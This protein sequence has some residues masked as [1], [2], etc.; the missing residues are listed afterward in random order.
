ML[1]WLSV[2][3]FGAGVPILTLQLARGGGCLRIDVEGIAL[4]TGRKEETKYQWNDIEEF[5]ITKISGNKFVSWNF[6]PHYDKSNYSAKLFGRYDW[7][8]RTLR[9]ATRS[10]YRILALKRDPGLCR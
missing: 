8:Y 1:G 5:G 4:G 3:F 7:R 9:M 10:L 2:T 6:K